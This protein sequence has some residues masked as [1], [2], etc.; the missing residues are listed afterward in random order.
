MNEESPPELPLPGGSAL[1]RN[2]VRFD[3]GSFPH[4]AYRLPASGACGHREPRLDRR[5]RRVV[6]AACGEALE[7]F[8]TLCEV[9]DHYAHVEERIARLQALETRLSERRQFARAN[10]SARQRREQTR[11]EQARLNAALQ[12]PVPPTVAANLFGAMRQQLAA[13]APVRP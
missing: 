11:T 7:A 2:V 8:Q 6:C 5:L 9:F 3:L 10:L 12:P 1:P 13:T 4:L